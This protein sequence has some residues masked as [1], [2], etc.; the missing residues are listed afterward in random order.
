MEALRE[1]LWDV[2]DFSVTPEGEDLG[3][4]FGRGLVCAV[5]VDLRWVFVVVAA[6]VT[7]VPGLVTASEVT[8]VEVVVVSVWPTMCLRT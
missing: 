8:V 7:V 6:G 4:G 5:V 3:V 2:L 1:G